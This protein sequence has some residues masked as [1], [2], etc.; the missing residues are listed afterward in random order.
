MMTPKELRALLD[1]GRTLTLYKDGEGYAITDVTDQVTPNEE[2]DALDVLVS[3]LFECGDILFDPDAP[4]APS[5]T[6]N[7]EPGTEISLTNAQAKA[8]EAV[9]VPCFAGKRRLTNIPYH[10]KESKGLSFDDLFHA[11]TDN[12]RL[13][14]EEIRDADEED[15]FME[16]F[17]QL[18]PL[19]NKDGEKED[20]K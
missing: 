20:E 10:K 17:R 4:G 7:N 18:A 6:I 15:N 3:A 19:I 11:T 12:A 13:L 5:L 2:A 9:G 16:V 1:E 8:L 14:M